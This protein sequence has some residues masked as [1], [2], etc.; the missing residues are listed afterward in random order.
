MEKFE[1]KDE[2]LMILENRSVR[3]A[4]VISAICVIAGASY[5]RFQAEIEKAME[6]ICQARTFMPGMYEQG[7]D[8][9]WRR[10][11]VPPPPPPMVSSPLD[12]DDEILDAV[13]NEYAPPEATTNADGE[14]LD[15]AGGNDNGEL[16]E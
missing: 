6:V 12:D 2:H 1:L 16:L 5:E 7:E 11:E 9:R 15:S 3:R 14:I 13:A 8:G 4:G 10:E